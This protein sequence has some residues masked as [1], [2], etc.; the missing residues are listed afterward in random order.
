MKRYLWL[1]RH[2]KSSWGDQRLADHDRPLN[3]RGRRTCDRLREHLTSLD[4]GPDLVLCS[5]SVR[6][7]ETLGRILPAWRGSQTVRI[8]TS[9]Y[10]A[11]VSGIL[12]VLHQ[13]DEEAGS[14]L[15]VGHNPGLGELAL[16]LAGLQ[17]GEPAQRLATKFPTGALATF[18]VSVPWQSLTPEGVSLVDFVVPRDL[19]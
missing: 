11:D 1:L 2:A 10:G 17:S 8:L 6:T 18:E 4:S 15:V 14:V 12:F 5:S 9:L 13:L 19:E 7:R 16:N 3:N